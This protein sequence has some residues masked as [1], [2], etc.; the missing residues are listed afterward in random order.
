MKISSQ[1]FEREKKE[2]AVIIACINFLES[3]PDEL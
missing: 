2:F 3:L 1:F